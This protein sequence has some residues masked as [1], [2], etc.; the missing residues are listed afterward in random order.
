MELIGVKFGLNGFME[1]WL[2]GVAAHSMIIEIC[3]PCGRAAAGQTTS[4][5]VMA[6]QRFANRR[7]KI[8]SYAVRP[9]YGP[10]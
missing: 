4:G 1:L 3:H 8:G 7:S 2:P 6:R 10:L 5:E 9:Y